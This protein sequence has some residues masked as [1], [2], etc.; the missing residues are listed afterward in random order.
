MVRTTPTLGGRMHNDPVC[1]M[2]VDPA[3]TPH[4]AEHAGRQYH[5]CSAGCRA[6]F[7]A[8]PPRYLGPTTTH[9]SPVAPQ[10]PATA[11]GRES[12][13]PMPPQIRQRGPG[14]CP[15]CGMA[16]EPVVASAHEEDD[17][18]LRSMTRRFVIGVILTLP[19][20]AIAMSDMF[21]SRPLRGLAGPWVQLA[22]ATPVVLWG[23]WPFFVRGWQSV[24]NR[25]PNMFTL[26]AMGVGVAYVFSLVAT[27]A[28]G[29]F[30]HS[31]R[32]HNGQVGVYFE[33][34]A[35]IV[36][37]VLLGQVMELR[38]RSQTGAAIRALLGL[39]PKTARRLQ[40]DGTEEDI[41]LDHVSVGDR[42]RVR[43]GE[44]VPVDGT[45]L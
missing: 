22:L 40:N 36:T 27:I 10:Q 19:L 12:T 25:S 3:R 31:F 29:L 9:P 6:Q 2:T 24:V 21:P 39:A 5:F 45:V 16:L 38:A 23:G 18:E 15:I 43:P 34:A 41:P 32:M 11:Y 14:A 44:K 30:P 7:V 4:H 28:P 20:L 13:S 17:P 33:A 8:D 26:I 1:G 42:L 37:L 35:V